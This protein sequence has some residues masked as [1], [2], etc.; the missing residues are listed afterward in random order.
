MFFFSVKHSQFYSQWIIPLYSAKNVHI[1]LCF[2]ICMY[3]YIEGAAN[4][5]YL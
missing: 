5:M 1:R 4:Q 3:L 2:D